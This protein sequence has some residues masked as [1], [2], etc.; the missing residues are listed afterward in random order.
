M[1]KIYVGSLTDPLYYFEQPDTF[2]AVSTQRVNLVGQELTIDTFEP[3]V[4]DDITKL[5]SVS[6]FRSSDGKAIIT[7]DGQIY[8]LSVSDNIVLSG[9]VRLDYGTPVWYYYGEALIGKF[10]L[11][12][13]GHIGINKYKLHCMSAVGLLDKMDHGGGL[14]LKA[15]FGDVLDN[16]LTGSEASA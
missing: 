9:L 12:K 8:A 14:F 10:Y 11:K 3:V 16:I 6:V 1:Y 15:T 5:R 2:G 13:T 7:A 4:M